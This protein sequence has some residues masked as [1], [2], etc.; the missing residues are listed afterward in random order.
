MDDPD[1]R[2]VAAAASAVAELDLLSF[3]PAFS[4]EDFLIGFQFLKAKPLVHALHG[5]PSG[6]RI[7]PG[8]GGFGCVLESLMVDEMKYSSRN[9]VQAEILPLSCFGTC[10]YY[11]RIDGSSLI[12]WY[13]PSLVC[14]VYAHRPSSAISPHPKNIAPNA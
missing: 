3:P 7:I 14:P 6:P 10:T 12:L 2:E 13:I 9:Y 11:I 4:L 8:G 1:A 5:F